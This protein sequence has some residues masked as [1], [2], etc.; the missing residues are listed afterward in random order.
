[1]YNILEKT[2]YY[3]IFMYMLSCSYHTNPLFEKCNLTT[4]DEYTKGKYNNII[5]K[6]TA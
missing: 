3:I 4:K 6:E 2:V 1:M 5:K